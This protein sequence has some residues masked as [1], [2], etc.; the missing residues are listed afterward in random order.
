[1]KLDEAKEPIISGMKKRYSMNQINIRRARVNRQK[2]RLAG[3]S[4][5]RRNKP[6][7]FAA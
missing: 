5:V 4:V 7:I 6:I 2:R 1:V 3:K